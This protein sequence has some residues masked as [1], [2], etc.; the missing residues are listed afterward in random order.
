M[1][2]V[3][4]IASHGRW[5]RQ[6]LQ[7]HSASVSRKLSRLFG[8]PGAEFSDQ[9]LFDN[10]VDGLLSGQ[11]LQQNQSGYLTPANDLQAVADNAAERIL[12]PPLLFALQRAVKAVA[13]D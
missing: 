1:Y 3:I 5:N 13:R 8:L 2:V 10:F 12:D 6:E 9:S 7:H 4:C 11:W